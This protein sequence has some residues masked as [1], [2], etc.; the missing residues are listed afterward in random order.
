MADKPSKG[1][2][3]GKERNKANQSKQDPPKPQ[4]KEGAKR[5]PKYPCFI[6]NEYHYTKDCPRWSEVSRLLKG[7][8]GTP[9]MLKEPFPL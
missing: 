8:F 4:A 1:K 2:K 7:S 5:K 6:C 3:K 9:A